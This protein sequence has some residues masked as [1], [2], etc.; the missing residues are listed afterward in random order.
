MNIKSIEEFTFEECRAYLQENP[1]GELKAQVMNQLTRLEEQQREAREQAL[2]EAED[3]ERAERDRRN[4]LETHVQWMDINH[5]RDVKPKYKNFRILC[6][7]LAALTA[8]SIIWLLK[9]ICPS[10]QGRD[11]AD[12]IALAIFTISSPILLLSFIL[13]SIFS[14]PLLAQIRDIENP[15][16]RRYLRMR[17][18][19]RKLGLCRL[20]WARIAKLLPF[21]Y[22]RIFPCGAEAYVCVANGKRGLYHAGMRKMV[23]AVEYDQ[24]DWIG[25]EQVVAIRGNHREKFTTKGF[26]V[27]ES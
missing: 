6:Y 9:Y 23:L 14:S 17:N 8:Y 13:F 15:E 12:G 20:G 26:R 22:D 2:R 1:E 19:E 3:A 10:D 25:D 24:I 27:V 21:D 18:E 7:I 5:F 11:Y 4:A 16:G